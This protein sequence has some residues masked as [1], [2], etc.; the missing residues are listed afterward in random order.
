MLTAILKWSL[1][2]SQKQKGP[3]WFKN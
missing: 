1:Y 3:F 2:C